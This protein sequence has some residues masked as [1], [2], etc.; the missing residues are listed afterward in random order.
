VR[1]GDDLWSIAAATVAAAQGPAGRDQ[2]PTAGEIAT[3]WGRVLSS[4]RARLPDPDNPNLI[5]PG[6]RIEL[7]PP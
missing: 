2:P 3:Y 5:F 6:D 4:N 1:P 7:P